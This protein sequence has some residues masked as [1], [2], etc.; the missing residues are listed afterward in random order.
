M[1][2]SIITV[3][4]NDFNNIEK[5]ILSVIRQAY[6]DYEYIIIDGGSI[7]GTGDILRKYSNFIKHLIIE[8]DL[9]IYDAMNKGILL[10]EGD[11]VLFINS[12]DKLFSDNTLLRA[13]LNLT[14]DKLSLVV[15]GNHIV[16]Y[17]NGKLKLNTTG[18]KLN[19][20]KG[21]QFSHQSAF[22]W[23]SYH[24]SHLYNLNFRLTSDHSFF[25]DLFY[26]MGPSAFLKINDVICIISSGG[27][28]DT[29]RYKVL[30]EWRTYL[31]SKSKSTKFIYVR[32]VVEYLKYFFKN[33]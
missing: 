23:L 30:S 11:W 7:D 21:S 2:Y 6:V 5:T 33:V 17:P 19:F 32:Y 28:S 26:L 16:E 14:N 12:G 29:N 22:I 9:G 3:V 31:I 10:A 20:E 18:D 24:K 4:L 1:K 25:A 8:P 27:V 13:S 15:Y